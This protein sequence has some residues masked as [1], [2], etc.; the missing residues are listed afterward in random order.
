MT[1]QP[2]TA[3]TTGQWT[4]DI[5]H[6][7]KANTPYKELCIT[8]GEY[9]LAV[10][11]SDGGLDNPYTIKWEEAQANARLM[12]ACPTL[13]EACQ[14]A[15]PVIDS[16]LNGQGVVT[17]QEMDAALLALTRALRAAKG[18]ETP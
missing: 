4:V 12:A 13:L 9:Q 14:L 3:H 7:D 8:N 5:W 18:L 16:W 2:K 6:Y 1:T 10:I 11:N 15:A 17:E